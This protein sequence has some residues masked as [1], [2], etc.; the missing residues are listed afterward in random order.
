MPNNSKEILSPTYK[1]FEIFFNYRRN[2]PYIS[3]RS[4][5][6]GNK[7]SRMVGPSA[8]VNNGGGMGG[9]GAMRRS[10]S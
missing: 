1:P 7:S 4:H 8:G 9:I 5:V 10:F 2:S 3:H 6:S